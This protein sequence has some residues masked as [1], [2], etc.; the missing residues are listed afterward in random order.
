[1]FV[2][3][4]AEDAADFDADTA[5]PEMHDRIIVGVARRMQATLLTHDAMITLRAAIAVTW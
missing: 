3:L 1:M 5:I 4:E 2:P